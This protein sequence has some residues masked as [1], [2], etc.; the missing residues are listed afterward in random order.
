MYTEN[1]LVS[2]IAEHFPG[3]QSWSKVPWSLLQLLQTSQDDRHHLLSYI[4]LSQDWTIVEGNTG[5]I[6]QLLTN[7]QYTKKWAAES[8]HCPDQICIQS[9]HL[10]KSQ[11][12]WIKHLPWAQELQVDQVSLLVPS[13]PIYL[14]K[15]QR[16]FCT[17]TEE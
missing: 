7:I 1:Y 9:S 16:H 8:W 6:I 2:N 4:N 12:Y 3:L 5:K 10:S 13:N 14:W 15:R 17:K 11:A